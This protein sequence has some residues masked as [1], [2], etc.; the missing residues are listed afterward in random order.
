MFRSK[1]VAE[2]QGQNN[3]KVIRFSYTPG[4]GHPAVGRG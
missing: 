1:A 2:E 4:S 3:L